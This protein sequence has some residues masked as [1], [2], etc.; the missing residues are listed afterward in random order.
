MKA[1][2]LQIHAHKIQN[3]D[4]ILRKISPVQPNIKVFL[5][6]IYQ[7]LREP[8]TTRGVVRDVCEDEEKFIKFIGGFA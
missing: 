7:I 1:E 8:R 4:P 3:L 2:G 5:K 6:N